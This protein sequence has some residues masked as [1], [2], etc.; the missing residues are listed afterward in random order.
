MRHIVFII[1]ITTVLGCYSRSN[2]IKSGFEGEQ[3]PQ[4][5]LLLMDSITKYITNAVPNG[6]STVLYSFSP[7]CPYCKAQT[8]DIIKNINQ[9]S[10]ID[11][12]MLS[13]YPFKNIKDY[14]NKYQLSKYPNIIVGQDYQRGFDNH[15]Q[16]T[17]VPY[18]TIFNNEKILVKVILGKINTKE[19]KEIS[20]RN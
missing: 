15:Y 14:Y 7:F 9:L 1:C 20:N 6:N 12:V 2:K 5:T 13:T 8:E 19:I 16:A 17:G 3:L 10:N 18:L 4:F 11:F